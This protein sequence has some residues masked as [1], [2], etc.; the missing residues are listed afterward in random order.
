[1]TPEDFQRL[2]ALLSE[3][4]LLVSEGIVLTVNASARQTFQLDGNARVGGPLS[5]WV[6]DPDNKLTEY[7]KNCSASSIPVPGGLYFYAR[8]DN[9]EPKPFRVKGLRLQRTGD[10][11]AQIA[12]HCQ[13]RN[14]SNQS[15]V[16]LNYKIEELNAEIRKEQQLA[17]DL[18]HNQSIL[19]GV[20]NNAGSV[21]YI[22][23][24]QG[25][26]LHINHYFERLFDVVDAEVHGKTDFDLFPAEIAET[27]RA[28]DEAVANAG[29][30]LQLE[31]TMPN[32]D[33]LHTYLSV[34]FP[35]RDVSGKIYAVGGIS[36]DI[37][38]LKNARER[39]Q[40]FNEE[41]EARVEE[42]TRDLQISNRELEVYSYS[43]AHD[44]RA[45]LRAIVSFSQIL[46]EDAASKLDAGENEHLERISRAGRFMS[47]LI[48]DIL[49]LG[50]VTRSQISPTVVDLSRLAAAAAERLCNHEREQISTNI[51]I[52]P[53]LH[54]YGDVGLLGLLLQNLLDNA[55]KY[56]VRT[57]TPR[58]EL[59][60]EQQGDR[61]VYYVRDN[62]VGFDMKYA[63]KLF[64]P[65]A[66]L[67][68]RDEYP[69]TGVGL[70][71]VQRIVQRH[72]GQIWVEAISGEG[73]TFYFTLNEIA[74]K[75]GGTMPPFSAHPTES[76]G[77]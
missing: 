50:R 29:Q 69:G 53:N 77:L 28:N 30:V 42:R 36:T 10:G 73:A 5:A 75:N 14:Q 41:L 66:R 31:E 60:A 4:L 43:I 7:L 23:D 39:L 33:G 61:L 76:H 1:M 34:K 26:Y 58:I 56:S 59:G 2:G 12:L 71:T 63:G 35:L 68:G 9:N 32:D 46:Q 8:S 54:T 13:P 51:H 37:S 49:E 40:R 24:L 52:Q 57:E 18:R 48:D 47:E 21:I 70:A 27:L 72:G 25:C 19:D 16:L 45:P 20:V 22:K 55:C 17:K 74:D 15:F 38:E 65:F 6:N 64:Q 62:G 11:P 44:L 67:H 3:P